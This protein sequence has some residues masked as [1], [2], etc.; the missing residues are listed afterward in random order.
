[1]SKITPTR[2]LRRVGLIALVLLATIGLLHTASWL[3]RYFRLPDSFVSPSRL[4]VIEIREVEGHPVRLYLTG[5]GGDEE[6]RFEGA[7]LSHTSIPFQHFQSAAPLRGFAV[8]GTG[9]ILFG[10]TVIDVD[11]GDVYVSGRLV[12]PRDFTVGKNGMFREGDARIAR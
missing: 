4:M 9:R 8:S 5:G 11:R 2:Q 7:T 10:S 6:V 12:N 3:I 1:M